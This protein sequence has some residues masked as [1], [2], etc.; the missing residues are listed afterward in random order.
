[1]LSQLQSRVTQFL[2]R[3]LAPCEQAEGNTTLETI[4]S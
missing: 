1:M 3:P 4:A 2:T